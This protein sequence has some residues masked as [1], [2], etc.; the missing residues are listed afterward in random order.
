MRAISIR[1]PW[2]WLIIHG[3]KDIENR[4]WRTS[5]RGRVLVHAAAGMTRDEWISAWG[6]A[7]GTGADRKA[8]DAGLAM[9][10][11]DRGGIVGSVYIADCVTESASRWFTGPFGFVLRNPHPLP[12]FPM[13]GRLGFFEAPK[14]AG[15]VGG[16][17]A[18]PIR[19]EPLGI[20]E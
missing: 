13:R 5:F 1:Q 19:R 10:N 9:S 15:L 16:P 4:S 2:A 3:G 17:R 11:I 8:F 14:L 7:R 18:H 12:F 6:F 20:P